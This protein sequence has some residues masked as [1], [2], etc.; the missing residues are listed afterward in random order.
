MGD[1]ADYWLGL[2]KSVKY[3]NFSSFI[4]FF[5]CPVL[6]SLINQI[7]TPKQ[8]ILLNVTSL[9]FVSE[10]WQ[11]SGGTDVTY[12]SWQSGNSKNNSDCAVCKCVLHKLDLVTIQTWNPK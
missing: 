10:Q 2:E 6:R 11:W 4:A 5:Y 3:G 1:E 8:K 7:W 12:E 9:T